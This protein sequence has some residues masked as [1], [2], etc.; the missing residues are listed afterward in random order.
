MTT[1][2]ELVLFASTDITVCSSTATA[3]LHIGDYGSAVNLIVEVDMLACKLFV[4]EMEGA[5]GPETQAST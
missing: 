2:G 3:V 4:G 1:A 5:R